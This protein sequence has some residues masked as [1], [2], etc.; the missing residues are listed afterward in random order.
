MTSTSL[1][2]LVALMALAA[3]PGGL[4]A[5]VSTATSNTTTGDYNASIN[6]SPTNNLILQGALTLAGSPV[7]S[8]PDTLN[9]SFGFSAGGINDGQSNLGGGS[10]SNATFFNAS[11]NYHT[12]PSALPQTVTF[13]LNT[14]ANPLGYNLSGINSF[15]G[16]AGNEQNLAD[17]DYTVSVLLVGSNTFTQIAAVSYDPFTSS[18]SGSS[19]T[20]VALTD[21]SGY[22]ATGVA[23]VQ[24]DFLPTSVATNATFPNSTIISELQVLGTATVVPEPSTA[25]IVCLLGGSFA[26]LLYRRRFARPGVASS[27]FARA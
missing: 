16:F 23:E 24:F 2:K 19:A 1:R 8:M 7:F 15:A 6:P 20:S 13:T 12:G 25:L 5:A 17:Q 9:N 3:L 10:N 14:T 27:P 22:L 4:H 26:G 18:G 11:N 21:N